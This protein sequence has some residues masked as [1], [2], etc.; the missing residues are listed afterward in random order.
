MNE[1]LAASIRE[2]YLQAGQ[3]ITETEVNDL[4]AKFF[5]LLK[6]QANGRAFF[7]AEIMSC[8]QD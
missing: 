4:T 8:E 2:S 6:Q 7:P 1:I 3:S 5:I